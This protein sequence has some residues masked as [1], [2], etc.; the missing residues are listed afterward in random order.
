[1]PRM[2]RRQALF[3][4][5]FVE[6]GDSKRA[7]TEA[8]YAE[9][10]AH[11]E[12]ARML[13]RPHVRAEIERAMV[14]AFAADAPIARATLIDIC[15]NGRSEQ[16]RVLAAGRLLDRS[17]GP[18]EQLR[19]VVVTDQRDDADVLTSIRARLAQH[20]ELVALLAGSGITL[21]AQALPA[22]ASDS[23][24]APLRADTRETA[25]IG[26]S[27]AHDGRAAANGQTSGKQDGRDG[28]P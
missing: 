17:I 12:G 9:A 14:D 11:I 3:V 21:E 16:A 6:T 10:S 7:A 18:V 15:R 23:L 8:G 25:A 20:P 28:P 22:P 19:R 13:R 4:Q 5:I 24:S 27:E 2:T 26:A 1:M